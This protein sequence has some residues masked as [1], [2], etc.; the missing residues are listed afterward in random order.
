MATTGRGKRVG[1]RTIRRA[2]ETDRVSTAVIEAIAELEAVPPTELDV[3]IYE[4][5]DLDALDELCNDAAE[6]L[7]VEARI[8]A[9]DV[10]VESDGTVVAERRGGSTP[11]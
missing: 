4:T 7:R 11:G 9:Y 6:G 3:P 10:S 2:H 8:E 1:N 5:I